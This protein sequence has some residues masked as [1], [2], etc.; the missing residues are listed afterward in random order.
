MKKRKVRAVTKRDLDVARK[1][2]LGGLPLLPWLWIC[3][4]LY[5]YEKWR[6]APRDRR[7]HELCMYYNRYLVGSGV[8]V[9]LVVLWTIVFQTGYKS[10]GLKSWLVSEFSSADGWEN[11]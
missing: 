8:Y 3:S 2:F 10:L 1:M 5:F 9:A 6:Y 7:Y 4:A 11:A